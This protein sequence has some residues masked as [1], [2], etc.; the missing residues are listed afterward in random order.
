MLWHINNRALGQATREVVVHAGAVR[1]PEGGAVILPAISGSG[2]STLVAGLV[3]AG[4][5]YLSDEAA[6][7]DPRTGAVRSFAKALSLKQGSPQ[8][9]RVGPAGRGADADEWHVTAEE[10]RPGSTADGAERVR[11]VIF[12]RY[13]A[14]D[15]TRTT[16]LTRVEACVEMTRHLLNRPTV[17][18]A[19]ALEAIDRATQ[20]ATCWRLD[21]GDLD[22][23][24]AAVNRLVEQSPS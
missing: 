16:Q 15:D 9:L 6:R 22:E 13:R 14:D 19:M 3:T 11:A 21:F 20:G 12:P 24:V 4:Y 17:G 5:D 23:A 7:I 1:S 10:L 8:R 18:A 2:K